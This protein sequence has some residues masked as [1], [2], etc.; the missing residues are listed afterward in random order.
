MVHES[1]GTNFWDTL[2][3]IQT[4][5]W[6]DF[7]GHC[8]RRTRLTRNLIHLLSMV[9]NIRVHASAP[10]ASCY[11]LIMVI[12]HSETA[13]IAGGAKRGE[14]SEATAS[15][16][17]FRKFLW[18]SCFYAYIFL[19]RTT[20]R[21]VG[22]TKNKTSQIYRRLEDVCTVDL[23]YNPITPFGG[24]GIVVKCDESKFNHKAKVSNIF[25]KK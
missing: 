17:S 6:L 19:S 10:L 23:E 22:L 9:S 13:G 5:C 24:P 8:C 2:Y 4:I 12:F 3:Y 11:S 16:R 21:K 7:S 14:A 20:S 15:L 1:R 25:V 18:R